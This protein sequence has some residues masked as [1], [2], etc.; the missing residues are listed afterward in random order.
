MLRYVEYI[1][2]AGPKK[3]EKAEIDSGL[4]LG[5][6]LGL[7]LRLGLEVGGSAAG[8]LQTHAQR[9]QGGHRVGCRR[10]AARLARRVKRREAGAPGEGRDRLARVR[11][12]LGLGLGLGLG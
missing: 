8:G 1:F 4:G 7:R 11:A 2:V 12:R 9:Q 5:L 3:A 10:S 6:G